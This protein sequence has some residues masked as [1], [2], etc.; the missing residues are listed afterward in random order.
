[1]DNLEL[2][3]KDWKEQEK[4]L[5]VFGGNELSRLLHK[6]SS[7]IVKWIFIISVLEFII[8]NLIILLSG[9]NGSLWNN[10]DELGLAG[11][12]TFFY[13]IFYIIIIY[14]IYLF[15]KNYTSISSFSDTKTLI[16][17]ILNTRKTV[18]YYIWF[19]LAMAA[20][21]ASVI[22]YKKIHMAKISKEIPEDINMTVIW[23]ATIL[24]V[25]L[26]IGLFYLFYRILYGILLKRLE[27]NYK[28]LNSNN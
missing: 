25:V 15:Y 5:P 17:N 21:Y 9:K 7:S 19:N 12:T 27:R 1:M 18:K 23:V 22:S 11:F 14:F 28:E 26:V 20:I 10:Y 4:N 3:K 13:V 6:K 2:L 8:P 24:I 16:K